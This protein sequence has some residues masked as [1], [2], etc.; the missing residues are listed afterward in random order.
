M[1][2]LHP[3]GPIT[4]F[5]E[6]TSL[7][8]RS[9][10]S[11]SPASP[12]PGAAPQPRAL[13]AGRIPFVARLPVSRSAIPKQACCWRTACPELGFPQDSAL[14]CPQLLPGCCRRW[15]GDNPAWGHGSCLL[16]R[17]AAAVPTT[18]LPWSLSRLQHPS[19]FSFVSPAPRGQQGLPC[20]PQSTAPKSQSGV[21]L[22]PGCTQPWVLTDAFEPPVGLPHSRPLPRA[23]CRSRPHLHSDPLRPRKNHHLCN[24]NGL[25]KETF[26]Q[27]PLSRHRT[28]T[29]FSEILTAHQGAGSKFLLSRKDALFPTGEGGLVAR[30][31]VRSCR[32]PCL[33]GPS[34]TPP[35]SVLLL[36]PGA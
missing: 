20:A 8:K 5:Y 10:P 23:A 16:G 18:R 14:L 4:V 6:E 33:P 11:R 34:G 3:F 21:S 30:E 9:E 32:A 36:V 13:A 28:H 27:V 24:S 19:R 12:P 22:S 2:G 15:Q 31:E 29:K 26:K 7:P 25:S 35:G 1:E 17:G